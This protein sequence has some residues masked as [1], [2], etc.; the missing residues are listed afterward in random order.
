MLESEAFLAHLFQDFEHLKYNY[1]LS[2]RY[3]QLH[4][5]PIVLNAAKLGTDLKGVVSF[6]GGLAGPAPDK[7]NLKAQVLVCHGAAD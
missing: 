5:L 6:H 2:P 3:D 1:A 7:N 4:A